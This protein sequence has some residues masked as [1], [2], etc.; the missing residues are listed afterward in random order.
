VV[1]FVLIVLV[2]K[3]VGLRVSEEE[4]MT[5]CDLTQHGETAYVTSDAGS[6]RAG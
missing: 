6:M 4:E 2:D 5:G 1:S 3:T